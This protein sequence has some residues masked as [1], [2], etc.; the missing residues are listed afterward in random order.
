M[1]IFS[2]SRDP[3]FNSKTRIRSLKYLKKNLVLNHYFAKMQVSPWISLVVSYSH[4]LMGSIYIEMLLSVTRELQNIGISPKRFYWLN[5]TCD[6][7]TLIF[8]S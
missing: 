4:F 2:D 8:Y 5:Y 6:G 7:N 1:I 3:I